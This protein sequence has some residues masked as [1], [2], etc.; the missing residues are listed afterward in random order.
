MQVA[1]ARSLVGLVL[2]EPFDRMLVKLA[3]RPEL[4]GLRR[5]SSGNIDHRLF[6][7]IVMLLLD[8]PRV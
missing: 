6:A 4:L 5:N 2:L 8:H 7:T 3:K 1:L